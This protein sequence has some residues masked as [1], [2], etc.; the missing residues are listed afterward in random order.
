MTVSIFVLF[1]LLIFIYSTQNQQIKKIIRPYAVILWKLKREIIVLILAGQELIFRFRF[2]WA[3]T[4]PPSK[5]FVTKIGPPPCFMAWAYSISKIWKIWKLL[6]KQHLNVKF[7][8]LSL[9]TLTIAIQCSIGIHDPACQLTFGLYCTWKKKTL[10]KAS[11]RKLG[12]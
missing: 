12:K 8:L 7:M 6:I 3:G 1:F 10:M 11:G 9:L 2:P 5:T 4:P